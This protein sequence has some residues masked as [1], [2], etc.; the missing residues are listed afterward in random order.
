MKKIKVTKQEAGRL[1]A[2]VPEEQAFW[3]SDGKVF[4]NL[5]D[6]NTGL[7]EMSDETYAYHFNAEKQDFSNWLK[8]VVQD[9]KLASELAKPIDRQGATKRVSDRIAFLNSKLAQS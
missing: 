5:E 4:R 1:L 8:D 6:L 7:N 3:S 2:S 9:E